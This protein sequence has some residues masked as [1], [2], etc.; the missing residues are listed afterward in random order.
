MSLATPINQA[1]TPTNLEA[2]PTTAGHGRRFSE[3]FVH[4]PPLVTTPTSSHPPSE[5]HPLLES[6]GMAWGLSYSPVLFHKEVVGME[7]GLE[8][9]GDSDNVFPETP[10]MS[11]PG[12]LTSFHSDAFSEVVTSPSG[13]KRENPHSSRVA[14][15]RSY[16]AIVPGH[17]QR[18]HSGR[19]HGSIR[20]QT[21]SCESGCGLP[22]VGVVN[23]GSPLRYRASCE[24][25]SF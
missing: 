23:P 9:D 20:S 5:P 16:S 25:H 10:M 1:A 3:S 18:H 15:G 21:A 17:G 12:N 11:S 24:S 13:V 22:G 2:T 8:S 14:R 7:S 6:A 4:H 19:G